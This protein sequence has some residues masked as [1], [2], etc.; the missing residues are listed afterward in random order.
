MERGT[1]TWDPVTGAFSHTTIEDTNGDWGLSDSQINSV[2]VKGN[3]ITATS[4]NSSDKFV[5]PRVGPVPG[6]PSGG[7]RAGY[8]AGGILSSGNLGPVIV[9]GDVLGGDNNQAGRIASSHAIASVTIG[10]NLDGGEGGDSGSVFA[11]TTLGPVSIGDPNFTGNSTGGFSGLGII[12]GSGARSGAVIAGTLAKIDVYGDMEG[13][14]GPESAVI[15]T[16]GSGAAGKMG[17]VYIR[18]D[19]VGGA[20]ID[21]LRSGSIIS[22]GAITSVLIG[23]NT[24]DTIGSSNLVGG[25]AAESGNIISGLDLGAV[26]VEGS[27]LGGGG[28]DSGRIS[29][30][31]NIASV[32]VGSEVRGAA[33]PGS[34]SIVSTV[35]LGPVLIGV[36]GTAADIHKSR[37][38]VPRHAVSAVSTDT[39]RDL[40]G[41]LGDHSGS[42]ISGGTLAKIDIYG[43]LLG[44]DGPSSGRIETQG[45]GALGNMGPVFI[46]RSLIATGPST[47]VQSGQIFSS[48][49]LASV[50]IGD[51]KDPNTENGGSFTGGSALGSGTIA[52][53]LDMGPVKIKLNLQGGS[54]DES[55]KINSGGNLASLSVG[56]SI[57]GGTGNYDTTI[58]SGAQLGQVFA[59]GAI[60]PVTVAGSIY[61]NEVTLDRS[62][63]QGSHSG[64]IRGASIKSVT[65]GGSVLGGYGAYSGGLFSTATDI[66]PVTIAQD[67]RAGASASSGYISANQ[68]IASVKIG[69][70]FGARQAGASGNGAGFIAAGDTLGPVTAGFATGDSSFRPRISALN[71]ITSVTIGDSIAFTDI[72][73]GLT[74]TGQESNHAGQIGSVVIGTGTGPG[75]MDATNILAGF[76]LT[77]LFSPISGP[78]ISKIA[79]VVVK[80][81]IDSQLDGGPYY[82]VAADNLVAF[83]RGGTALPLKTGAKNDDTILIPGTQTYYGE[84][85]D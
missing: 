25:D 39:V 9:M 12:G 37:S 41:G 8:R 38:D 62:G 6:G 50:I 23:T 29:S 82:L 77:S 46:A 72:V 63:P 18:G 28:D 67:L 19:V 33:G 35:D 60:G 51:P 52:S 59:S 26:Y 69:G 42:V 54:G 75:N 7:S 3:V 34:G 47:A 80:G 2:T 74:V 55:G 5:G 20:G 66:G 22:S 84:L 13:D 1:Y 36:G 85:P 30:G 10:G 79:S 65:V 31:K 53:E 24:S 21:S 43:Y 44:G 17:A 70:T 56:S 45:E 73:A 27:I 57:L 14:F 68:N 76:S 15:E 78:G 61:G 58:E 64:E 48:G 81:S 32:S 4:A 11:Q 71:K 83:S 40:V 49:K 16:I